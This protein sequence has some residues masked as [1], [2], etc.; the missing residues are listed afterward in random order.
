[1]PPGSGLPGI[2]TLDPRP[3]VVVIPRATIDRVLDPLLSK[4]C[5][6]ASVGARTG[7]IAS[8]SRSAERA[9]DNEGG[10]G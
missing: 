1:M 7:G 10:Q 5:V 3:Q 8:R 9:D 6:L 4:G 2:S